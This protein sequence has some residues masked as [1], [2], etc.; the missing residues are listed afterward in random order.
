MVAAGSY[1]AVDGPNESVRAEVPGR[2]VVRGV[3]LKTAHHVV[4]GPIEDGGASSLDVITVERK[5]F[6]FKH[7]KFKCT[8]LR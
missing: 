7:L 6:S 5:S 3:M 8:L 1:A 2:D 4:V